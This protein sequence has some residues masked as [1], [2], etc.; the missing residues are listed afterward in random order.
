MALTYHIRTYGCQMNER[1]SEALGCLLEAHGYEPCANEQEADVFLLNTCSVRA[2]AEHKVLGKLG[3][4]KRRK[5]TTS[6]PIIGVLGCMAQ[7]RGR[8]LISKFPFLDL[9]VGTD[10]LHLLPE[11]IEEARSGAH[12]LVHTDT[13]QVDLSRLRGHVAGRV[14]AYVA[15]MRGCNQFCSYCVV[16]YVRG[17]ET[18][19][20]IDDVV[21]E[22]RELAEAGTKEVVLLGQNVT[23]YGLAE[24]KEAGTHHPEMSPFADLL[25][26]VNDVRGIERIRFTSP[27]PKYMNDAFVEAVTTLPKVCEAIHI[28]MQSG[29]DRLLR[30]M[31]RGYTLAQYLHLIDGIRARVPDMAFSTDV[32]VGYPGETAEEFAMTRQAMHDAGFVMAY[33][34]RYSTR[35]GTAAARLVDDV[36][37]AV[38]EERN[39][40][41]L[42]DLEERA[43]RSNR[44]AVGTTQEVLAD[45]PSKRNAARW[46]GRSRTNKVCIFE[47]TATTAPGDLVQVRISRA[48]S[49]TLFGELEPGTP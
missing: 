40:I 45:G 22:V 7:K 38:K 19:R 25:D 17:R 41:L 39:Q 20:S 21:S 26:A 1:D 27:H 47:P 10:Q 5:E 29:S 13:G 44:L 16:P 18:S 46:A 23:A 43:E 32:I 9:V 6:G 34:F 3:L 42:T 35:P 31:R 2:Q 33:I 24:A 49:H 11:L 28:P 8:Q 30:A 4:L 15:V 36:P 37:T 48:T 14:S 12:G